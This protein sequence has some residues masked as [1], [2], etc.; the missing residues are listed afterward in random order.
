MPHQ[1]PQSKHTSLVIYGVSSFNC[2]HLTVKMAIV[3]TDTG[4]LI[5][6]YACR[7]AVGSMDGHFCAVLI[8]RKPVKSHI[9]MHWNACKFICTSNECFLMKLSFVFNS[10]MPEYLLIYLFLIFHSL[11]S[12]FLDH[13]DLISISQS[14]PKDC[15]IIKP[16]L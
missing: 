14:L 1:K 16:N 9:Q 4:P 11:F 12:S 3:G 5:I 10:W 8:H 2:S 7:E 13:R 15:M 6:T